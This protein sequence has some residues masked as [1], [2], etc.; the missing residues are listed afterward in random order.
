MLHAPSRYVVYKV[1]G[2]VLPRCFS[3]TPDPVYGY[4]EEEKKWTQYPRIR[5]MAKSIKIEWSKKR[6]KETCV[7]WR[8]SCLVTSYIMPLKWFAKRLPERDTPGVTTVD[9]HIFYAGAHTLASLLNV[10]AAKFASVWIVSAGICEQRGVH[11]KLRHQWGGLSVTVP[12]R[13]LD[14]PLCQPM[15]YHV[16]I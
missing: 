2:C 3:G 1:T 6:G 16:A 12:T 15:Q 13:Q 7:V 4:R 14:S 11:I 9:Y 5:E 10:H 8:P